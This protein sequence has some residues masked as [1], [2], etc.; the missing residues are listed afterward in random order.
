MRQKVL[1]DVSL[2]YIY[3]SDLV[4][5]IHRTRTSL[6]HPMRSIARSERALVQLGFLEASAVSSLTLQVDDTASEDAPEGNQGVFG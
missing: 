2:T 5:R 4:V 1:Q 3:L 6:R